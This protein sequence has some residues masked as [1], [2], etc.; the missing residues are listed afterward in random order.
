[1]NLGGAVDVC[2]SECCALFN[3]KN[4]FFICVLHI[5][6]LFLVKLA[7]H[8]LMKNFQINYTHKLGSTELLG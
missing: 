7:H 2:H 6:A 4:I 8:I 1:M 3:F 5:R